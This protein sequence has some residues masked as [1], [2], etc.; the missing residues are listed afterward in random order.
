MLDISD[1]QKQDLILK[2]QRQVPRYTSYPTAPHFEQKF[3]VEI[4]KK[5]LAD[6]RPDQ[7]ISLYIHVPF[8][9]KMCWYCGCNTRV[10]KKYEPVKNYLNYL[11]KEI[12]NI[13]QLTNENILISQIHFGGGTPNILLGEDFK[14]LINYLK[15]KFRFT[16]DYTIDCEIDPRHL[17]QDQAIAFKETGVTRISMG[18]QD[19]DLKTQNAINRVQPFELVKEKLQMLRDVGIN[20][21]NLDLIYG[22]PHQ[23][24][25]TME[26]NIQKLKELN[27]ER[28]SL[29]GYAHVPWM[30]KHMQ[31]IPDEI[32]PDEKLRIKLYDLASKRLKDH[33]YNEVGIDHFALAEDD[34]SEALNTKK[35][36]RNFQGYVSDQ[37]K[38]LI[39]LGA[40]SISF[41][42]GKGYIQ[43]ATCAT[44]YKQ[45]IEERNIPTLKGLEINQDDIIRSEIISE[46]MCH[47]EIDLD[48]IITKYS[49]PVDE[50]TSELENLKELEQDKLIEIEAKKI[51]VNPNVRQIARI[52]AS[53]FDQYLNQQ[54]QTRH[55]TNT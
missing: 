23:N 43:N 28:I 35:L 52:V 31:L 17:S 40:S 21:F 3:S 10:T 53:Y 7:E 55:S 37:A 20:S 27:S 22:L 46:I 45:A 39:A 54:Q 30:K 9:E 44:S 51:K 13:K 47:L 2:Y 25:E 1:Q 24:L 14:K 26:D 32:L 41:F 11:F 33:G 29:F 19:F 38:T 50:F 42:E 15:S 34:L 49:L 48:K 16:K 18:V 36:R 12:D 4:H 5:W 8:C 6:I